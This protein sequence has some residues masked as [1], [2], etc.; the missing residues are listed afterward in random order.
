MK[1]RLG[2]IGPED[3]I[4]TISPIA[5]K[6]EEFEIHEFSYEKTEETET[7]ILE[8]S[9]QIDQ[10]LF[11]GQAPYAFA[12]EKKLV[13]EDTALFPPLHGSSLLGKLLEAQYHKP[14]KMTAVSLDTIHT[15]EIDWVKSTYNLDSL[16]VQTFPYSGYKPAEDIVEFHRNKYHS[17]E[18]EIAFTCI[19]S[20]YQQLKSEGIPVYRITVTAVTTQV[21]LELLKERGNADWYRKSQIAIVGLEVFEANNESEGQLY[22]YKRKH[23]EL[24]L[25]R[26]LLDY[27]EELKGSLVQ[28]GDGL[29]FIYT[30]RGEIETHPWPFYLLES[31]RLQAKLTIRLGVGYG[32][33]SLEAEQHVRL[34]FRDARKHEKPVII[35]VDENK[36]ITEVFHTDKS[37]TYNQRRL[38]E[39]WKTKLG[40]R[41]LSPAVVSKLASFLKH[42]KKN[43]VTSQE[44]SQWLA[45]SERNARRILHELEEAGLAT[46]VGEE[47]SGGRG[48]PRK[49][50]ELN[51]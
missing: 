31:A 16:N 12:M 21:T 7:I 13:T 32:L 30:T 48:R 39:Q 27:T 28:M 34:A 3:S 15:G 40:T 44:V 43:R 10:W 23:Q 17:G 25:K 36:Q 26:L 5:R 49:I 4:N 6:Y 22:S 51:I 11:S 20:V 2:I 45:N 42:Y 37:F 46:I 1:I 14:E 33:T 19:R 18:S 29:F 24:E 8:N 35:K 50:Y 38:N 41:N 9:S 47:Q